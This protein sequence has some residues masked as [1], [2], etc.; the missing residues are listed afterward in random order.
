MN[1]N[2]YFNFYFDEIANSAKTNRAAIFMD[3]LFVCRRE[4]AFFLTFQTILLFSFSE[5]WQMNKII[6][7]DKL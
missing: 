2:I 6:W 4:V 1:Q 5:N 3:L 7:L